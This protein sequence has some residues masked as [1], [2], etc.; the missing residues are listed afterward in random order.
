MPSK[1]DVVLALEPIV[2]QTHNK[3]MLSEYPGGRGLLHDTA[4][5]T[6]EITVKQAR[7]LISIYDELGGML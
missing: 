7:D 4:T 6:L 1:E 3:V 5:V 2:S